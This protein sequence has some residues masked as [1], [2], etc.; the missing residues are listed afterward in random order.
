M[1]I[2]GSFV[3][4]QENRFFMKIF[5]N[6]KCKFVPLTMWQSYPKNIVLYPTDIHVWKANMD[7]ELSFQDELWLTLSEDE[8][9]RANR[10]RFPYLRVRYIAARGILRRLLAQYLSVPADSF[11]FEYG[12]QGK[13]SLSDFPNFEF[14]ISHSHD[15]VVFAFAKDMTLGIDVE[16]INPKIDCEVIA[17]RFFS[18][19]EANALLALP[20]IERPPIFFNCWTRKE[21]FIKAKGGGLSIPLDQFEVTLLADDAPELLTIDWAPEE[22]KNWS[23]F[24][25]NV[26]KEFVG[27]LMT[28]QNIGEVYYYN[29]S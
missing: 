10:F 29:F 27:A 4:K 28:N 8:K 9:A 21:A 15:H 1:K 16:F 6:K 25:F 26:N 23:V 22:V 19:N 24:S 20:S 7:I 17:P 13:P 14:N 12:E 2:I 3:Y 18:K 5:S 11:R